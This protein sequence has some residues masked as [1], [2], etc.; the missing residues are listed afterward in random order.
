[1]PFSDNVRSHFKKIYR[2]LSA[3]L[4]LKNKFLLLRLG[5][6]SLSL[7]AMDCLNEIMAKKCVPKDTQSFLVTIF[8]HSMSMIDINNSYPESFLSKLVFFLQLLASSQFARFEALEGFPMEHFLTQL[9]SFT[10]RQD[11]SEIYLSCLEV[12]SAILEHLKS[13]V[14]KREPN[15]E[16]DVLYRATVKEL[17]RF[18]CLLSV[19]R[20]QLMLYF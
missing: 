14:D 7:L 13:T 9:L 1:M 15:G 3:E 17:C 8:H 18:E 6:D 19:K 16:I 2:N 20:F 12:W 10:F 4:Q 11:I 5:D